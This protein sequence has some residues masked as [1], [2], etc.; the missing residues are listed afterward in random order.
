MIFILFVTS[1]RETRTEANIL[2]VV[3]F[4]ET[5]T[6]AKQT[7]FF[8]FLLDFKKYSNF[9]FYVL[10]KKRPRLELLLFT[11]QYLKANNKGL[12]IFKIYFN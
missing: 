1:F 5:R 3:S 10:G 11:F 8:I 6:E 2:F 9:L 7:F 4:R 12:R